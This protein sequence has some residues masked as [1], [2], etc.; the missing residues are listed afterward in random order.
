MSDFGINIGNYEKKTVIQAHTASTLF[1]LTDDHIYFISRKRKGSDELYFSSDGLGFKLVDLTTTFANFT[2]RELNPLKDNRVIFDAKNK[3]RLVGELVSPGIGLVQNGQLIRKWQ[4]SELWNGTNS[5]V[6]TSGPQDKEVIALKN[7]DQF[8]FQFNS[9]ALNE[10]WDTSI[11]DSNGHMLGLDTEKMLMYVAP[12]RD[13]I[14]LGKYNATERSYDISAIPKN[15]LLPGGSSD[16]KLLGGVKKYSAHELGSIF[17]LFD[18]EAMLFALKSVGISKDGMHEH[19]W[20]LKILKDGAL[21][22]ITIPNNPTIFKAENGSVVQVFTDKGVWLLNSDG[23]LE[24]KEIMNG[25]NYAFRTANEFRQ[26]KKANLRPYSLFTKYIIYE[27]LSDKFHL[28][29]TDKELHVGIRDQSIK[30]GK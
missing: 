16:E 18:D 14:I 3:A 21:N 28:I 22:K 12:R 5:I 11:K 4:N 25:E 19:I 10:K 30:I 15:Q 2:L 17:A 8:F 6:V 13:G 27:K 20:D 7:R 29:V 26:L 23:K 24:E 1:T 9:M